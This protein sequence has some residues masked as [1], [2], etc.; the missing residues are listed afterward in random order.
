[1]ADQPELQHL[2]VRGFS[3]PY[4]RAGSGPTVLFLHGAGGANG[5]APW[6]ASLAEHVDLIAPEHP[7]FD[8]AETPEWLDYTA[9]LAYFYLDMMDTLDLHNVHIIGHS[10]GGWT[11]A[12][13][14]IRN[15]KRLAS[16]T[17]LCAVG[18]F[19][20]GSPGIDAFLMDPEAGTKSLVYSDEL[21]Q[22]VLERS[23]DLALLDG[24]MKNS[25]TAAKLLWQP[26]NYNPELRKW[27]HRIDVPTL[28]LWGAND[29][30]A[31]P[32]IADVYEALIPNTRKVL[33]EQCGHVPPMEQTAAYLANV[34]A[35]VKE[36]TQ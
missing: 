8:S 27:L 6:H 10:L 15:T 16:L 25:M 26:R 33:L 24:A 9:D 29:K 11:A 30:I 36:N 32:A 3:L 1:M 20:E 31:P 22:T 13:L 28:L 12:E 5:W 14:A 21:A 18:V 23:A 2:D 19:A 4:R 7:G 34:T 35:F 17:L